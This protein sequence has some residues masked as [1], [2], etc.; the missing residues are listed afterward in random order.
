M[1]YLTELSHPD[2]RAAIATVRDAC[3]RHG[4]PFG[5]FAATEAAAREWAA[6]GA[7]FMTIGADT[8]YL[9]QGLAKTRVLAQSLQEAR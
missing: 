8:Q 5:I 3:A 7:R 1:G 9:D 4:A 6:A 2:V